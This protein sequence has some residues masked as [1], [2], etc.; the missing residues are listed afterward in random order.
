MALST[1][2]GLIICFH[3]RW[4]VL[5]T[6]SRRILVVDVSDEQANASKLL[7]HVEKELQTQHAG[8]SRYLALLSS[9]LYSVQVRVAVDVCS[10]GLPAE[11]EP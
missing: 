4:S 1:P 11:A 7:N 3:N 10:F 2:Y 9:Q 8:W 5:S 6:Q